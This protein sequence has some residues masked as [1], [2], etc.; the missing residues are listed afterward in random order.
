MNKSLTSVIIE[1]APQM[2]GQSSGASSAHQ[3]KE[4][5]RIIISSYVPKHILC[6][7]TAP[8]SSK[9]CM[10]VGKL[11]ISSLVTPS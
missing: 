1:G 8:R 3:N 4:K 11:Q 5:L 10:C 7:Y 6:L 2:F 9:L